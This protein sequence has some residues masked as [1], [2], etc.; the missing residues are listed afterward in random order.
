M[1]RITLQ[2]DSKTL[3]INFILEVCKY[4]NYDQNIIINWII[5]Q[6]GVPLLDLHILQGE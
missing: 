2:F 5:R 4:L 6:T 1:K 3:K